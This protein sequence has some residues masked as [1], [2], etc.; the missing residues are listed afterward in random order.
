LEQTIWN[1]I[2]QELYILGLTACNP[3]KVNRRLGGEFSSSISS[4]EDKQE[5]RKLC[6]LLASY[7]F[8]LLFNT[9]DGGDMS[10]RNVG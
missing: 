1:I 5:T 3:V 4:V 2:F 7:W 9:E 10:V 8:G 6:L